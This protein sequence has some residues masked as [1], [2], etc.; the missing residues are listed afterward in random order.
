MYVG[1]H[2]CRQQWTICDYHKFLPVCYVSQDPHVKSSA[3]S[4]CCK[5][6]AGVGGDGDNLMRR[7][8]FELSGHQLADTFSG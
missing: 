1:C 2:G 5:G 4:K 6:L 3:N 8:G 7:C